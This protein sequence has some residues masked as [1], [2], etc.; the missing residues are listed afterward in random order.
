LTVL[1][2][3]SA[4]ASAV[5]AQNPMGYWRFSD[6]GGTNAYDYA[7]GNDA[8]DTNYM[9]NGNGSTGNPATLASGPQPP[10]FPGFETTNS[11]PFLDGL[12]QGYSASMGLFNN[13]SNF[14]LMGWF[15]INP[16]QYPITTTD[17]FTNPDGRA[18]LFGEEWAAE[19]GLYQ[20][21]NLYFYSAGISQT[22]FVY[23]TNKLT[24][25][26]WHFVAAVSDPAAN[27]TT[28]YLDGA[29][30]GTASLCPGTV[31]PYVF[32]IGKN[33]AYFPANGYDNAFFPGSL[34][35]VAAFDHA[36]P[37]STI[38]ALYNAS[39]GVSA[40]N[41][42]RTNLAF[43]V[44]AGQLTLAWPQDHTGWVLEAQTNAV[45]AGLGTNWVRIPSS[46]TTNQ[47]SVPV[48]LANPSVF[49]RLVYP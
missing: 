1:P 5:I 48:N 41:Q 6:G 31:Q 49:Y 13:R 43:S 8:F 28:V 17:P 22:I 18:S 33:V 7:G 42:S 3:T 23:D 46:A 9:N 36:L 30:A 10:T 11:A 34:D 4:Y 26:K 32:S 39:L 15:N 19:L 2:V 27:A 25:G 44:R 47:V 29:V 37:A 45:N 38:Q 16:S 21:T 40:V 24:A 20:G 14:T 12:S 35:E